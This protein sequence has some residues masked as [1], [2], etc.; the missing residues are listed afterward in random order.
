MTNEEN[1]TVGKLLEHEKRFNLKREAMEKESKKGWE[2]GIS[3]KV[4]Q[5]RKNKEIKYEV[6][7]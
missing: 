2:E 4:P 3:I 5:S 1:L 7:L 6:Q